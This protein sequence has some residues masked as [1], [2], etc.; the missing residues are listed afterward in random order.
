MAKP[1]FEL[2]LINPDKKEVYEVLGIS[3]ER[4]DEIAEI[5]ANAY[6]DEKFFTDSLARIMLQMTNLNE[7]VFATLC[8]A[9]AHDSKRMRDLQE[10]M[11][12]MKTVIDL[13]KLK[14]N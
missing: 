9:R 5:V 4:S 10:K 3:E 1:N 7:V 6:R 13:M 8:A 2:A 11:Q 12:V 14:T